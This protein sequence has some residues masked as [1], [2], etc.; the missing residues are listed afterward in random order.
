MIATTSLLL[1]VLYALLIGNLAGDGAIFLGIS[2]AMLHGYAPYRDL[3]ETKPPGIFLLGEVVHLL[4]GVWTAQFFPALAALCIPILAFCVK[5]RKGF[6]AGTL[7]SLHILSTAPGFYPEVFG[8]SALCAYACVLLSPWKQ[9]LKVLLSVPCLYVAIL[10]K[11]PFLLSSLGVAVVMTERRQ[12]L[13]LYV[14]P[15]VIALILFALTLA[16][17]QIFTI[18]TFMYIPFMV[19]VRV[20]DSPRSSLFLFYRLFHFSPLLLPI[21]VYAFDMRPG[22]RMA[23][24][25]VILLIAALVGNL[26]GGGFMDP[27]LLAL[28]LRANRKWLEVGLVATIL[29]TPFFSDFPYIQVGASPLLS[30]D[31]KVAPVLDGIMERCHIDRYWNLGGMNYVYGLTSHPASGP[32]LFMD[33]YML[34][35]SYLVSRTLKNMSQVNLILFQKK[36]YALFAEKQL[37]DLTENVV[38]GQ[39]QFK[40][41]ECAEGET[42]NTDRYVLLFRK[43][44]R[45]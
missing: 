20:G 23:L 28:V 7:V 2:S 5:G 24:G 15:Q 35:N 3:F 33:M 37:Y 8:V 39:F 6:L 38:V 40:P 13:A 27:I 17:L 32:L 18:Y 41:W 31:R 16:W 12:F 21:I 25:S 14:L 19:S 45:P 43:G 36:N 9:W 29:L 11:E 10:M 4:G 26:T 30:A 44:T 22:I 1:V 42:I 34:Q